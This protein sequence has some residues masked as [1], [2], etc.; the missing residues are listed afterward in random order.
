[1]CAKINLNVICV[2]VEVKPT[3]L[4]Y[5]SNWQ[6]IYDA[7]G[8]LYCRTNVGGAFGFVGMRTVW[9]LVRPQSREYF[10]KESLYL[11]KTSLSP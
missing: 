7:I 1:M 10:L 5:L 11:C 4:Y 6:H 9:M 2:A 3:V 8:I